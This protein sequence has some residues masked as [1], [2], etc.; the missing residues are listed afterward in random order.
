[1]CSCRMIVN[2]YV[3]S[4]LA[5]WLFEVTQEETI[6]KTKEISD[7]TLIKEASDKI[8]KKQVSYK[9]LTTEIPDKTLNNR[10]F[11]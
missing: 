6:D 8:I 7:K 1:M 2:N 11:R 3:P 5:L 10:N 9:I 4:I